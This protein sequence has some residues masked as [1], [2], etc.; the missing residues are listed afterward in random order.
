MGQRTYPTL[1]RAEFARARRLERIA[2][3][4]ARRQTRHMPAAPWSYP[5]ADV[6]GDVQAAF[7]EFTRA[8][9]LSAGEA[10]KLADRWFRLPRPIEDTRPL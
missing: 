8:L 2:R 10:R 4:R 3:R 5:D 7:A 6:I 9:N 1:T